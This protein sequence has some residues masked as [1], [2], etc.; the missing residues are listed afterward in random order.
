MSPRRATTVANQCDQCPFDR[1]DECHALFGTTSAGHGLFPLTPAAAITASRLANRETFRPRMVLTHVV[2]PVIGDRGGLNEGQFPSPTGDIKVLVDGA[3]QRRALHDLPLSQ[4]EAVESAD[5]AAALIGRAETVLRIWSV[6]ES[7]NPTALLRALNLDLPDA[8][9]GGD[10][11]SL[12][13]PPGPQ[14]PEPGA[15]ALQPMVEDERLQAV[16]QWA[17]GRVEL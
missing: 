4:L 12:L 6:Q 7:S 15:G 5:L 11:P 13:P 2:G 1:R 8:A 14:P 10:G 3:I 9:T 17:G 16:S